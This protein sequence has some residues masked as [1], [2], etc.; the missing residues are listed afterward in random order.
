LRCRPELSARPENSEP[1]RSQRIDLGQRGGGGI[2]ARGNA[3]VEPAA[4]PTIYI[5]RGCDKCRQS[6][7]RGRS[8][9]FELVVV[10]P[11]MQTMIH[12]NKGEQ[13][14]ERY[15]RRFT[16]SIRDDGC[17]RVLLGETSLEE[18]VRVT[19]EDEERVR[20]PSV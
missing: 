16:S 10:D 19:Q 20:K 11:T 9:I 5:P 18:L 7:Y 12:E 8:G 17:R 2:L 1:A 3:R 14:M 15:A 6:G 13:D 4:T